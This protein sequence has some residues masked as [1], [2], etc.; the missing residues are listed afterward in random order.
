MDSQDKKGRAGLSETEVEA[1]RTFLKRAGR[2]TAT[3]P[4][5]ALLLAAST[6]AASAQSPY[7]PGDTAGDSTCEDPGGSGSSCGTGSS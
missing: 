1:R 3:A 5:V 7:S 4:A 2:A 6:K